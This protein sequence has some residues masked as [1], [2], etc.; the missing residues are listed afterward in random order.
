MER[1]CFICNHPNAADRLICTKCGADI[2]AIEPGRPQKKSDDVVSLRLSNS[3]C[4][5]K[6][7][8]CSV[9][10]YENPSGEVVCVR[11][12]A[13][14]QISE[15][16]Y[17]D[18]GSIPAEPQIQKQPELIG[19]SQFEQQNS[20]PDKPSLTLANRFGERIIFHPGDI[21]GRYTISTR[22]RNNYVS[23]QHAIVLFKNNT[24]FI[25]DK[26]STNGTFINGIKVEPEKDYPIHTGDTISLSRHVTLCVQ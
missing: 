2:S 21:I 23:E 9:C 13:I 26:Q 14:I 3:Q 1:I 22:D 24:W 7:T 11:C 10:D 16:G 17:P 12:G 20:I 19:S 25:R 15:S 6:K 8:I 5:I 4:E 18:L